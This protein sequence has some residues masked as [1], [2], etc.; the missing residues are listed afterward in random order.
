MT[1]TEIPGSIP[2]PGTGVTLTNV[3]VTVEP[4]PEFPETPHRTEKET[5][6]A[7]ALERLAFAIAKVLALMPR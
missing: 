2:V 1:T 3:T 4:L 5:A 7:L 6:L